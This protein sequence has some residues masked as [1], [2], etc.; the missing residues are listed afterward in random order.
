MIKIMNKKFIDMGDSDLHREVQRCYKNR[1]FA[2][3][4]VK[5]IYYGRKGIAVARPGHEIR[6]LLEELK[7]SLHYLLTR[8]IME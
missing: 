6:F 2:L 5:P 8:S 3:T 1:K 7:F 4:N